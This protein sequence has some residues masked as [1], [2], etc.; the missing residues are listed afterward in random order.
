MLTFFIS[1]MFDT[2]CSL[3]GRV[4]QKKTSVEVQESA[5]QREL[6]TDQKTPVI[7]GF[8]RYFQIKQWT[9]ASI[10]IFLIK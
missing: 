10:I 6:Y 1:E 4:P 7:Q 2:C 9:T 5:S 3:L 8:L